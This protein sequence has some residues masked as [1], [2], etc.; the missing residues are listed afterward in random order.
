MALT[1][2]DAIRV[3]NPEQFVSVY[4]VKGFLKVDENNVNFFLVV[5]HFLDDASKSFFAI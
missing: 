1:I 2:R 4:R 3:K 5:S